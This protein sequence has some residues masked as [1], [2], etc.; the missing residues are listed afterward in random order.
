MRKERKKTIL[1]ASS[2]LLAVGWAIFIVLFLAQN[3]AQQGEQYPLCVDAPEYTC[4]IPGEDAQYELLP[5]GVS[6]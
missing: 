6:R 4:I 1:G 5:L 2:L 3:P